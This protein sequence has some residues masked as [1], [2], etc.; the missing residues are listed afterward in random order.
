MKLNIKK[1]KIGSTYYDVKEIDD[2][3]GDKNES[4]S[5]RILQDCCKILIN[6][7]HSYQTQ[8]HTLLHEDVHGMFWE[9][10]ID[11]VEDLVEPVANVF[12]ALIID[13]PKFIQKILDYT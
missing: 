8:L 6:K 12:Y 10:K 5:G 9:Y 13:N 2:L 3:R 11:D 4:L 7:Q 1:Q